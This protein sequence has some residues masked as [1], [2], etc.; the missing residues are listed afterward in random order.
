MINKIKQLVSLIQEK[1]IKTAEELDK[2]VSE[3]LK[4][5]NILYGKVLE[6]S[7]KHGIVHFIND[8]VRIYPEKISELENEANEK[9]KKKKDK[10]P[11]IQTEF[12]SFY[13]KDGK[14][15]EQIFDG[16]KSSFA[17]FDGKDVSY[18]YYITISDDILLYPMEGEAV[19]KKAILLPVK[20]LEFETI[21][22]LLEEI[23]KHIHKYVDIS[24]EFETYSAYY[25]LLSW[26]YDRVNTIPY[27]RFLGDT[28]CG[29]SRA[30]DVI[31]RLCYKA[32]MISGALTPAPIYRLI[33]AWGGTLLIDESDL[34]Q[35][36]T[37]NEIIK[38]LNCGF[39]RNR[40]VIRCNKDD[41]NDLEFF[42]TFCPKV[43]SSRYSFNDKALES[44][45][46]TEK[47]KETMR[48]DIPSQLP[49]EFFEKETEL[50]NKLLTFRFSY[51]NQINPDS[52]Q[53]IELGNIERRLKQAVS[54]FAA[55]FAN[56][57]EMMTK[58]KESLR[59]YQD[60]LVEE[61]S[62]TLEGHIIAFLF[63]ERKQGKYITSTT[64]KQGIESDFNDLRVTTIGKILKSLGIITKPQKIQGKTER[65][66]QW[67]EKLMENL[68]KR[69]IPKDDEEMPLSS[70]TNVTIVTEPEKVTEVTEVTAITDDASKD[71][72]CFHCQQPTS[73]IIKSEGKD[74]PICYACLKE[75]IRGLFKNFGA[76]RLHLSNFFH[77]PEEIMERLYT[78]GFIFKPNPEEVQL[79]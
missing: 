1:E 36:D 34:K 5:D 47:M 73:I 19:T 3:T 76:E 35:S 44:R 74:F 2:N 58:F 4:W 60:E 57:P 66:I 68:K 49:N 72:K 13:E 14:I 75:H 11:E 31:G 38:I 26:V 77:I 69:Y 55:L 8:S 33:N 15:Y 21:E 39:E 59:K 51:R 56:I 65:V 28:G 46:L 27:L 25:I 54:S 63:E 42:P 71:L 78:K 6:L 18:V 61:R 23:N 50:R 10:E 20:A 41:N 67:D 43:I 32:T 7:I 12:K 22:K 37:T 29:K 24:P 52:I 40:S 45:C 17:C 53:K 79:V 16:E 9:H 48:N 70:V 30:L 62:G 64:I